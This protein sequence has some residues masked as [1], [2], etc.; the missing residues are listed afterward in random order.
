MPVDSIIKSSRFLQSRRYTHEN[1][2]DAQ[3]VFDRVLDLSAAEI[4]SQQNLIPSSS[5][6]VLT[7]T[8]DTHSVDGEPILKYWKE[9]ALTP[10]SVLGAS[11]REEVWFFLETPETKTTPFEKN[12]TQQGNFISNKY[13]IPSLSANTSTDTVRGY[14]VVAWKNSVTPAN[15]LSDSDDYVFDYKTGVLEFL[16]NAKAA[17]VSE[18][19]ITAYQYIG[20][21]LADD[22]TSGYS[23][24][25]SGSFAGDGSLLTNVPAGSVVG[26]NVS[27]I[28]T[29]NITASV[30]GTSQAF[31]VI[32]GSTNLITVNTQGAVTASIFT[33][34]LV[35]VATGSFSG[36]LTGL[37]TGSVSG[38][39]TGI[40]SG[41]FSGSYQGNGGGLTNIP[42]NSI[43]GLNLSRVASGSV[44][45]SIGV[46]ATSL[47]LVS[48]S[49]TLATFD[50]TGG[51]TLTGT[52][53]LGNTSFTGSV[54]VTQDFTVLGTASFTSVTS[55]ELFI[56]GSRILLH[57]NYPAVRFGG[58]DV[59]DDSASG[60]TG[61]LLWDSQEDRWIYSKP[62]G[63]TY[64]GG[65]L[66]SGPRNTSGLGNEVALTRYYVPRSQGGDHIEDSNM[67]SSGSKVLINKA[68]PETTAEVE[69]SGSVSITGSILQNSPDGVVENKY[70]LL[71][72]QSAWFHSTN[73]GYPVGDY[74]WGAS[75]TGSVFQNYNQNTDTATIVRLMAGFLSASLPA[76]LPN[77]RTYSTAVTS[78]F[79]N[80][81]YN[82]SA[83][84]KG[85]IPQDYENSALAGVADI[86]YLADKGFASVGQTV[87]SGVS[88]VYYL[89]T[90]GAQYDNTATGTTPVSSSNDTALF[91]A[92]ILGTRVDLSGSLTLRYSDNAL[93]TTTATSQSVH[94]ISQNGPGT[95]T[96]VKVF[97]IPTANAAIISAQWQDTK[98]QS[99]LPNTI[100]RAGTNI[101]GRTS[102]SISSSGYYY[103]TASIG[104]S[105]S[106]TTG[107]VTKN[108]QTEVFWAPVDQLAATLPLNTVTF[109]SAS[110]ATTAV[111]RS[112]SGAPYLTATTYDYV[113]TMSGL[114][115]PLYA[116]NDTIGTVAVSSGPITIPST[117][118]TINSSGFIGAN[119]T[120]YSTTNTARTAGTVP[121]R[122]DQVRFNPTVTSNFGTNTSITVQGSSSNSFVLQ[123]TA[124]NRNN[125]TAGLTPT[126]TYSLF[127]PGTFGQPLASGSMAYFGR[128]QGTD[129]ASN[130][131][132][133]PNETFLGENFRRY[134]NAPS[135]DVLQFSAAPFSQSF[136]LYNLPAEELQVKPG[137]LVKPGGAYKY[138]LTDPSPSDT[139]KYYVKEFVRI[140]GGTINVDFYSTGSSRP[141]LVPWYDA[142]S[143]PD[144]VAAGIMFE[145]T[146]VANLATQGITSDA[147]FFNLST[148]GG[149]TTFNPAAGTTYNS[150][151]SDY[152]LYN[153]GSNPS[154][155]KYTM[156]PD[157]GA[158]AAL[159][160]TYTKYYLVVRYK[161]DVPPLTRIQVSYT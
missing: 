50:N 157:N 44:S 149:A 59:I 152:L 90:F 119:G 131:G 9:H 68:V 161:G 33:G 101:D 85:L 40:A 121:F 13:V 7:A 146:T 92:G 97:T 22:K 124:R 5:V 125:S 110:S 24:S 51:L 72:S 142:G 114:F 109:I 39:L 144:G 150:F 81:T 74:Q 98:Y 4:Y 102:T 64:S 23:G 105:S 46:G 32:S 45:A 70:A 158:G 63:G 129:P 82:V 132:N 69:I 113:V 14:K 112:L 1:I 91:G 140:G 73:I 99:A 17:G 53:S 88:T 48:A 12:A 15:L 116:A 71:V 66:I 148:A 42:A 104:I 49:T 126:S 141:T 57:T 111:S 54:V 87:L 55:S 96:P 19:Y 43:V 75:L 159:N 18:V 62:A 154:T 79:G 47:Q 128:A 156:T 147:R 136:G 143:N 78:L 2:T 123:N 65:M 31:R 26:L 6:P 30:T 155:G 21:T 83:N 77:S 137:F 27:Q 61:S 3:D 107:Y 41:S 38:T 34:S 37:V 100:F 130:S 80:T 133:T 35:G 122:T 103:I 29:S 134:V 60:T 67:Y 106:A 135:N 115:E 138:W 94:E 139:F 25:F 145:S 86:K 8:G 118:A 108:T 20:R 151:G 16:T 52:S 120:V 56:S 160:S 93:K 153:G 58:M 36:S 76:P 117:T 127:T 28:A 10:S 84:L 11:N 89:P 95:G